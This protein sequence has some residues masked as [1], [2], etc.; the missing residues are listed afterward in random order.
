VAAEHAVSILVE[1]LERGHGIGQLFFANGAVAIGI[2]GRDNR[3]DRTLTT[4]PGLLSRGNLRYRRQGGNREQTG[5]N[6]SHDGTPENKYTPPANA[7]LPP[8]A[9]R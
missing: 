1:L 3:V 4:L 5:K 8:Q 6:N 7:R 2:E 9:D